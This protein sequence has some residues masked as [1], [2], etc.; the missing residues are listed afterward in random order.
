MKIITTNINEYMWFNL[1]Q[2]IYIIIIRNMS[3][4][5]G[6]FITIQTT[7]GA[8]IAVGVHVSINANL[9]LHTND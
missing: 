6:S 1:D 4:L 3:D 8:T 5:L 7:L 9:N 2:N